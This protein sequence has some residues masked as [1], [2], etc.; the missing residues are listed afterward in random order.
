MSGAQ[1]AVVS[2]KRDFFWIEV[3]DRSYP[4]FSVSFSF[5]K[6]NKR[7]HR[8]SPFAQDN[9]VMINPASYHSNL[10]AWYTYGE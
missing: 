2:I 9:G 10:Y 6:K 3:H 5:E 1:Q 8:I 7:R 4:G